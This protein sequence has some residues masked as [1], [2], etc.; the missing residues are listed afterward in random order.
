M[1]TKEYEHFKE[2]LNLLKENKPETGKNILK[3]EKYYFLI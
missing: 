3:I 2:I 1:V